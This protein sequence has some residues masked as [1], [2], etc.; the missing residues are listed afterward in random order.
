M[1]DAIVPQKTRIGKAAY[2]WPEPCYS[3]EHH[4]KFVGGDI[5]EMANFEIWQETKRIEFLLAW[6]DNKE[7]MITLDGEHITRRQ[8][9][10]Q[11][12]ASLKK[13]QKE[14]L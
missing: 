11:R 9:L 13:R 8:W 7:A 14:A 2:T 5:D 6:F 1:F 12:L 4:L 10:L 3:T